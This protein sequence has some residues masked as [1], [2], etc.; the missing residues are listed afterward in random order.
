M[1]VVQHDISR[2]GVQVLEIYV[3]RIY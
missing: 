1:L 2:L 3:F